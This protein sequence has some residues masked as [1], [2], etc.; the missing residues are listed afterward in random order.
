MLRGFDHVRIWYSALRFNVL[1]VAQRD[2]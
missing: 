2:E 1:F